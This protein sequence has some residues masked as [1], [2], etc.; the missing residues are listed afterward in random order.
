M[1]T[2]ISWTDETWN[3]AIGCSK[4]S[5]GCLRCY[6]E[7]MAIRLAKIEESK[8]PFKPKYSRVTING[9]VSKNMAEWPKELRVQEEI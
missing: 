3:V 5:D 7:K 9:K 8:T 2:K 6:A 1:G 4:V